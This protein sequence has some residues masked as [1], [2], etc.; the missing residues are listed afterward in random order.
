MRD[1]TYTVIEEFT[2]M[3]YSMLE[4]EQ[5]MKSL[6]MKMT[7]SVETFICLQD[8]MTSVSNVLI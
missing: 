8:Y 1:L 4:E 7:T 3:E 2:E 6:I 5:L